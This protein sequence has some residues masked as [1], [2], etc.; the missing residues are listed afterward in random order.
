MNAGIHVKLGASQQPQQQV[1]D[2]V[3]D[4]GGVRRQRQLSGRQVKGAR[5][6]KHLAEGVAGDEGDEEVRRRWRRDRV[7]VK[8]GCVVMVDLIISRCIYLF[9]LIILYNLAL[10]CLS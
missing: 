2:L 10:S 9:F 4:H 5:G 6:A 3:E 1:V 7:K 8:A